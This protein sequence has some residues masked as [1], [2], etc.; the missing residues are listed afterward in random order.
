MRKGKRREARAASRCC[1]LGRKP[2]V[3]AAASRA[4]LFC[5][6]FRFQN[7][8]ISPPNGREFQ[9]YG[10]VAFVVSDSRRWLGRGRVLQTNTQKARPGHPTQIKPSQ[11]ENARSPGELLK[12][13]LQFSGRSKTAH[14]PPPPPSIVFG[15]EVCRRSDG[16]S[17]RFAMRIRFL[18]IAQTSPASPAPC[19]L[20]R[21]PIFSGRCAAR[22]LASAAARPAESPCTVLLVSVR[23]R[24]SF[25]R[26]DARARPCPEIFRIAGFTSWRDVREGFAAS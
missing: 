17:Y 20:R 19:V 8:S 15:L 16:N 9:Y 13:R 10:L 6:R 2:G 23:A 5:P 12:R 4:R 11:R 25:R 26:R 22:A 24:L 18:S 1:E 7:P 21:V 14:K 3:A